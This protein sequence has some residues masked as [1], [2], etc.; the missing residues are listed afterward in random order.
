MSLPATKL[1]PVW[2]VL[3]Q[4]G[5]LAAFANL[6]LLTMLA[7]S[8]LPLSSNPAY[9][10]YVALVVGIVVAGLALRRFGMKRLGAAITATE[11]LPLAFWVA[12][13]IGMA[14]GIDVL[15]FGSPAP[16]SIAAPQ[17]TD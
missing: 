8:P 15:Q 11:F 9:L 17:T 10:A 5:L 3:F 13:V 12:L 16:P 7:A 2:N 4:L 6:A 1:A 14:N